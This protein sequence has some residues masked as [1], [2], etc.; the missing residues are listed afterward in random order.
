MIATM[1]QSEQQQTM[2][3][4]SNANDKVLTDFFRGNFHTVTLRHFVR[5][6]Q[7]CYMKIMSLDHSNVFENFQ[8]TH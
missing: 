3:V 7:I 5:S 4:K 8:V 6:N 2:D 1:D